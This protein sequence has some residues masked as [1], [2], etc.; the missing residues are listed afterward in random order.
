[1]NFS[2]TGILQ[3]QQLRIKNL[4]PEI[5]IEQARQEI[6]A[7]L[8]AENPHISSKFFY[9]DEGSKLFEEI[10][11]LDEY[12]P[13]KTEMGILSEIA[14]ELMNRN[15]SF[16]IME[17]GSGD[18]SKISILLE[19]VH[20]QN[21]KKLKYIPVD[22][23][24]T[25][26]EDSAN[27]LTDRFPDL[28]INGYVADFIHQIDNIPHSEKARLICFLGSTIGNYTKEEAKEILINISSGL[29][30]GDSLLIGFDLVKQDAVLHAAY[31]DAESVTAK[32]NKNILNVVNR[33]VE[34]D[35][36]PD[37][38]DHLAFFNK[39]KSRIEMHLVANKPCHVQ[40]PFLKNSISFKKGDFIHTE[41][42]H[43]FTL[44][45][46]REIILGTQ[47]TINN[48]YTDPNH[49]FALVEFQKVI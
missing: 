36:S 33:I 9:D 32:F 13:T 34:S 7:G 43:K 28:Q 30:N 12:Y 35:F 16:E 40:S 24:L 11:E 6:I 37:N 21:L 39:E 45:S 19:A 4:L 25:A 44:E 47:L 22:F 46:I 27:E 14:S 5:G 41:N 26:I 2:E 38:F 20:S 18:C 17:L 3:K 15:S 31:N 42:S 1:M 29:L 48:V 49:W 10:T 8:T 23:S